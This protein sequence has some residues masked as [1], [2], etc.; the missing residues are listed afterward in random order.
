MSAKIKY[1][2]CTCTDGKQFNNADPT[3]GQFHPCE[4][5]DYHDHDRCDCTPDTL[6]R[7][8]RRTETIRAKLR[9]VSSRA[10]VLNGE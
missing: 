4:D 1:Q 9:L 3:S 5:C 10:I 7:G 2:D 6:C 8:H